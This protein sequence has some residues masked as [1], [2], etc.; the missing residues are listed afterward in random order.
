MPVYSARPL[1][2]GT[3]PVSS[4]EGGKEVL[5]PNVNLP[6]VTGDLSSD[7]GV[8]AKADPANPNKIPKKTNTFDKRNPTAPSCGRVQ[9]YLETAQALMFPTAVLPHGLSLMPAS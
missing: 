5:E 9:V 1:S 3:R 7:P 4:M 6:A 8:C 2:T